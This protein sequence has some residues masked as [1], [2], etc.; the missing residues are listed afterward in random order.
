MNNSFHFPTFIEIFPKEKRRFKLLR[1]Y[2]RYSWHKAWCYAECKEFTNYLNYS[3]LWK[4][5]FNQNLYRV[6]ALLGTYC[7]KKFNKRQR[8]NIIMENFAYAEKLFGLAYCNKLVEQKNLCLLELSDELK[9]YLSIN[10]IDPLEGF[11]SLNIQNNEGIH[12]YDASFTFLASN[13]LLVSS[14]QGPNT[15]SAQ[16]LIKS[17]TKQLHGVRPMFM[18]INVFKFIAQHFDLELLGIPH[19]RQAKYRWNDHSKLLFNYDA[20]WQENGGVITPD[21]YWH[22]PTSLDIRELNTI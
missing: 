5:L 19:K 6:N 22:L 4:K 14:I 1:E 11:F 17:A 15:A 7:D 20:F 18:L 13:K 12:I 10:N 8:L 9:L 3:P 16:D 21:K 2:L